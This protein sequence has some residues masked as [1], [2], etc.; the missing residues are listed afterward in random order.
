[1]DWRLEVERHL[2]EYL[3]VNHEKFQSKKYSLFS[4]G[5]DVA[6][7]GDRRYKSDQ[8]KE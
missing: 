1:M 3:I 4:E 7:V 2:W 8:W 6:A 5:P